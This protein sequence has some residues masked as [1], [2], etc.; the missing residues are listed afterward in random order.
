[1]LLTRGPVMFLISQQDCS[2]SLGG[3][4]VLLDTQVLYLRS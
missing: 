2:L 3:Q 4:N 1:M